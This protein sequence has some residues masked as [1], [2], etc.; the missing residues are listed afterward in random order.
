MLER[1]ER[2][3]GAA[4]VRCRLET[5][6]THQ[7]R[8]HLAEHGWPLL[9][10]PIYGRPPRDPRLRQAAAAIGRQALHAR[11]LG[12]RHPVTDQP[13]RFEAEPPPDF[14]RALLLLR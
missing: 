9:A 13:L 6:R 3:H 12:F 1:I 8:V 2:L 10:D 14:D 4:L 5:G 11:V 7:I